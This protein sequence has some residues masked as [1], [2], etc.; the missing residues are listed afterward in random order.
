MTQ[1]SKIT[2][3][4]EATHPDGL[5][6]DMA[7]QIYLLVGHGVVGFLKE[8]APDAEVLVSNARVSWTDK[9]VR[10]KKRSK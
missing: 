2:L 10:P 6:M 3:T 1:K 7:N 8:C 9:S 5:G 4:Y